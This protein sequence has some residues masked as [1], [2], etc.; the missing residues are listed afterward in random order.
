M[1]FL[2]SSRALRQK[3]KKTRS[4]YGGIMR[5]TQLLLSVAIVAALAGCIA[6][7]RKIDFSGERAKVTFESPEAAKARRMPAGPASLSPAVG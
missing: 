2:R 6:F 3:V 5:T 4:G 7:E 1:S